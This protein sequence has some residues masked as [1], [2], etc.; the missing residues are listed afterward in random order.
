MKCGSKGKMAK[1]LMSKKAPQKSK[2]DIKRLI[3]WKG[4]I[5]APISHLL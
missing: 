5:H 2:K 3:R 4:A 1:K